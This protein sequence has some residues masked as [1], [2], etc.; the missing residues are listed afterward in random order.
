VY[1]VK[2][3]IV[4]RGVIAGALV[5][6]VACGTLIAGV[7]D[8]PADKHTPPPDD[9]D[10][11]VSDAPVAVDTGLDAHD[12]SPPPPNPSYAYPAANTDGGLIVAA[13]FKLTIQS[14]RAATIF[15]TLDG[16]EPTDASAASPSP[17]LVSINA[18]A[19]VAFRTDDDPTVRRLPVT[20][21]TNRQHD[22]GVFVTE[23]TFDRGGGPVVIANPGEALTGKATIIRWT[24][25]Q[26]CA[27]GGQPVTVGDLGAQR[28][29]CG[30]TQGFCPSCVRYYP[31]GL[32]RSEACWSGDVD[33]TIWPGKAFVIGFTVHAP[34]KPGSYPLLRGEQLDFQ[35][36]LDAGGL[37][38]NDALVIVR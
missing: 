21:D 28:I 18:S 22:L 36:D 15:Y 33:T 37:G 29:C 19:I 24:C 6:L 27:Q 11:N 23:L 7:D 13:P 2:V 16:G 8:T 26:W 9:H 3:A 25:D 14:E 10:A 31:Y 32:D 5:C 34:T 1:N 20:I 4:H 35:C 17:T 30:G 12:A 38:G